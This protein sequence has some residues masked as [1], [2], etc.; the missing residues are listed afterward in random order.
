[1]RCHA[2]RSKW[3]LPDPALFGA[4]RAVRHIRSLAQGREM[5]WS[6]SVVRVPRVVPRPV[7]DRKK[8][9]NGPGANPFPES[10]SKERAKRRVSS[11]N[12]SKNDPA[13]NRPL[14]AAAAAHWPGC[15]GMYGAPSC[16]A[17]GVLVQRSSTILA[18]HGFLEIN[19]LGRETFGA[20]CSWRQKHP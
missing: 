7:L 18:D 4:S 20:G 11:L 9:L 15:L 17:C 12:A 14:A 19:S 5:Q 16:R 13:S 10:S 8:F 1:M 3:L 6:R 2:G